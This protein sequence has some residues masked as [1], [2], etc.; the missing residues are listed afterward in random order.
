MPKTAAK[1]TSG[2][3]ASH[4]TPMLGDKSATEIC[5]CFDRG[6]G[7]HNSLALVVALPMSMRRWPDGGT[8]MVSRAKQSQSGG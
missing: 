2:G 3:Y 4:L 8:L 6:I 5:Y 1:T 7:I